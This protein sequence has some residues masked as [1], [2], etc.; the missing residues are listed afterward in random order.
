MQAAGVEL[1]STF[2]DDAG[3][4]DGRPDGDIVVTGRGR[5]MV[6][7]GTF[8]RPN[9]HWQCANALYYSAKGWI[10]RQNAAENRRK[11]MWLYRDL[12]RPE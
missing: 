7:C 11:I 6:R 1:N 8:A 9:P 2:D 4:E 5:V 10:D 3:E 12:V